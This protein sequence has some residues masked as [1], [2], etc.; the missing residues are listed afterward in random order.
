MS[1]P[2]SLL[3]LM[4]SLYSMKT[5]PATMTHIMSPATMTATSLPASLSTSFAPTSTV[6]LFIGLLQPPVRT[7]LSNT[8]NWQ[9]TITDVVNSSVKTIERRLLR[10]IDH[11]MTYEDLLKKVKQSLFT[12]S[13]MLGTTMP[14]EIRDAIMCKLFPQSLKG[15]ALKWF[16]Q[17][18]L[19]S[20]GTFKELAKFSIALVKIANCDDI[21][22][23]FMLKRGLLPRSSFLDEICNWKPRMIAKVLA[24]AR[25]MIEVEGLW[26]T[27]TLERLNHSRREQDRGDES[28]SGQRLTNPLPNESCDTSHHNKWSRR[29]PSPPK[30]ALE[31]PFQIERDYTESQ[32]D[33]VRKHMS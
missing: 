9:Q 32:R 2:Y 12:Q 27:A 23:L 5:S 22:A 30:Y 1:T 16:C 33:S 18:S 19:K 26:R 17:L 13:V 4:P 7:P 10:T 28:D 20:I 25:G 15:P 8:F 29:L 21:I 3:H 24:R 11:P 14:R 31:N 6:S